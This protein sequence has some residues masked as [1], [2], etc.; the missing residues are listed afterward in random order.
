MNSIVRRMVCVAG[1]A[2]IAVAGSAAPAQAYHLKTT[3]TCTSIKWTTPNPVYRVHIYE[4][5]D[6]GAD[7]Y[8]LMDLDAAVYD[9]MREFDNAGGTSASVDTSGITNDARAYESGTP[10]NDTAPTIHIGFTDDP[11][12]VDSKGIAKASATYSVDPVTCT[13]NE[14]RITFRDFS[15]QDWNLGTPAGAG[16]PY[17]TTQDTDRAGNLWFRPILLHEVLHAFGLDHTKASY[18]FMD[19][20]AYPWAGG[21]VAEEDAIRPLPDDLEALRALY[22]AA[23][24]RSEIALLTTWYDQ[25]NVVSG[26]AAHI[27][28]CVPSRGGSQSAGPLTDYYCGV[29]G[30]NAGSTTVCAGDQ[31]HAWYAFANY[32]TEKA[33]DVSVRMYLSTDD[34]Y[35]STDTLMSPTLASATV[36]AA[37]TKMIG[38]RFEVPSGLTSGAKYYLVLHAL[39]TTTSGDWVEDWTPLTNTQYT[40]C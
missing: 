8:D 17:Y 38:Q 32:S 29:G 39:G 16:E 3:S 25:N 1:V 23:G 22:P 5:V 18:S 35:D 40:A 31:L 7:V 14:V 9:V 11:Y 27:H 28:V 21:G 26:S 36:E 24:D 6:G 13:Y 2:A 33:D 30:P 37:H 34:V 15:L 12:E 10:F 4:F 19:W 20:F